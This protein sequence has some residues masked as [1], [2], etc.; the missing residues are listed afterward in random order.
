MSVTSGQM[1]DRYRLTREIG[2]GAFGSVWLAEDTWLN[3]RVALKIPHEVGE[4]LSKVL[5][6]PKLLSGLEHPNIIKLLTV[7]RSGDTVFMVMEYVE[8]KS[9][10]EILKNGPLDKTEALGIARSILDA[11]AHAHAKGVVHRDL[12]PGNILVTSSGQ[13]KITDF[14]TAHALEKGENTVAAGTLYYMPKEQ[15]L[16]RI[17]PASDLYS[18]GV[19]LFEML[20]GKLPFEETDGNRLIQRILSSEP[21]PEVRKVNPGI[22][23]ELSGIVERAM[24]QDTARRWRSAGEFVAAI[25]A[26]LAGNGMPAEVQE[27]RPQQPAYD[28]LSRRIPRLAESLG[29]SHEFVFRRSMGGRGR[30]EGQFMLPAV[31]TVD[32]SG[33]LYVTDSVKSNVQIFD[34]E[35]RLVKTLGE[36]GGILDDGLRF[37]SPS[38]IAVDGKGVIYVCDTKNSRVQIL[39]SEGTL[40]K[41]FGRALIVVGLHEEAGVIGFNYPRGLALDEEE[42]L[43]YVADSGN[44]RLRLFSTEGKPVQAL[45]GRGERPGEFDVPMGLAT[46]RTGKLFAVDSQNYR[47]QVFDRGLRFRCVIGRRGPQPGCFYHPPLYACVNMF[48]ELIVADGTDHLHVFSDEGGFIGYIEAPE[49]RGGTRPRYHSAALLGSEDLFVVEEGKCEIEQYAYKERRR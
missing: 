22:D 25:D 17:N 42:G 28:R 10:K 23:P 26:Y 44:H 31:P 5:A 43:L 41:R 19:M 32:E 34:K 6:E 46:G 20:A 45:G 21:V 35:C 8:G 40:I 27:P 2:S 49:G 38:A 48:D 7:G 12:K 3:K 36:E 9:L 33:R 4:D 1:L 13:V 18:V 24:R 37:M 11:L 39:D 16:G 15:L 14:G 29:R 47:V 30:G